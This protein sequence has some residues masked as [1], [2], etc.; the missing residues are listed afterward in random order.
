MLARTLSVIV[1]VLTLLTG[2]VLLTRV[3]L[4]PHEV[5]SDR[6]AKQEDRVRGETFFS[7]V[8]SRLSLL[9]GFRSHPQPFTIM[10]ENQEDARPYQEGLEAA[11]MVQEFL[12]EGFISR[13][14]VIFDARNIPREVGPVRSLRPYFLD[15]MAPWSRLV[16]HA[17]GSP[18]ALDRVRDGSDFTAINLLYYDTDGSLRKVGPPAP[19]NVFLSREK[20]TELLNDAPEQFVQSLDGP[21][22]P[23][24]RAHGGEPAEIVHVNF[25]N[26]EH[27]EVYEY[28]PLANKYKRTDGTVVS[29]ARPSN[30]VVLEVPIDSIGEY[31][32]LFMTLNGRGKALLFHSG[33]AWEAH[34]SRQNFKEPFRITDSEGKDVPF[35][36][37]QIWMVVLPTMDRVTWKEA[38]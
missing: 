18:E 24:G 1:L 28:L 32:R 7:G 13:F 11:L 21:L 5:A 6:L 38:D 31:G 25:Y 8:L 26:T 22:F 20:I 29:D 34:W 19:H 14:A 9:P 10:V 27:N 16:I 30:L 33:K 36:Y 12:V 35:T 2:V 23:V 4:F 15:G 3:P 37:G 17:G